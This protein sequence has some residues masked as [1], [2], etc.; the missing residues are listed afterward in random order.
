[1][2]IS[3]SVVIAQLSSYAVPKAVFVEGPA[4][5]LDQSDGENTL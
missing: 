5:L 3:R 1:M 4:M 2:F